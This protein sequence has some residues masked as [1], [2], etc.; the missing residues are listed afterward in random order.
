LRQLAKVLSGAQRRIAE[1]RARLLEHRPLL[2][3][4]E[5]QRR[6]RLEQELD[7]LVKTWPDLSYGADLDDQAVAAEAL[8]A[9]VRAAL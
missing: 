6:A 1:L 9:R 5:P 3:R 2:G 7:H 4:V 8:C